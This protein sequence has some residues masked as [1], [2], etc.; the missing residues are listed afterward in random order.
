MRYNGTKCGYCSNDHKWYWGM[1]EFKIGKLSRPAPM[2]DECWILRSHQWLIENYELSD[3]ICNV[4]SGPWY[5]NFHIMG[6]LDRPACVCDGCWEKA[7]RRRAIELGGTG[8][9][10]GRR[11]MDVNEAR[12]KVEKFMS[13]GR[14]IA[15]KDILAATQIK[16][17]E[18]VKVI[19]EL[20]EEGIVKQEGRKRGAKYR[21]V[22]E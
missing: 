10:R 2:C 8:L 17:N 7:L 20:T 12:A 6:G 15:K 5:S 21:M 11:P 13:T 14:K 9:G 19:R 1:H 18:W 3:L 22:L 16:H 4:C